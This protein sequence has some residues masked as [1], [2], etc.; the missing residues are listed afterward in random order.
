MQKI[1]HKLAVFLRDESGL[2]MVEA[3]IMLPLLIWA[4]VAIFIYWDVFRTINIAQKAGYS[5]ADLLSRQKT[6]ISTSFADGLQNVVT[7]LTPGGHPTKVRVTSLECNSPSGTK[8]CDG[9]TGSYQLLFS[10]SPGNKVTPLDQAAIQNWKATKVP[11]LVNGESV[12]VVE[13]TVEFKAQ[14]QTF[15]AGFL[16]G[17]EDATYGTFI[18]TKPRHRRLCLEGTSTCT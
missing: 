16:V 11:T 9:T 5:I 14:L 12:F 15:I 7:F 18:V 3:L 1:K 2:I 17:V 10:F 6:T 13:T 4:L 8:V